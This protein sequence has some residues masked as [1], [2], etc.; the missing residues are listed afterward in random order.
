M[1]TSS[2]DPQQLLAPAA[3]QQS[4]LDAGAL[5]AMAIYDGSGENI[6]NGPATP[7]G[8]AADHGRLMLQALEQHNKHFDGAGGVRRLAPGCGFTLTQHAHYPE[9][10]NGFTV[11]WVTHAARNNFKAGLKDGTTSTIADG[12]YRNRFA[13]VRDTVA[14]VPAA[15]AAPGSPT[16]FGTQTALV[17]GL[18]D[19]VATTT[20]DHQVKVQFGWQRGATPNPGGLD[21]LSAKGGNAPGDSS[22]GAWV[23]V[24]EALA[25]PNWGSQFIPRIGTEVLIAFAEGDIDR[26]LIV[27]QLHNGVTPPPY[28]AGVD[29]GANHVGAL[30]GIDTANFE[31]G[32]N[33][34]QLDDTQD[35]VRM[36][37]ASSSAASELH[38]G[39]A[40]PANGRFVATGARRA[41]AALNCVPTRGRSCAARKASC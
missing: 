35:Q 38:L 1:L 27:G 11:L 8:D 10:A 40:G 39:P 17:V 21:H 9:G 15:I 19:S 2:W 33:Q 41:A 30:S 34:W 24:A 23:R 31:G 3:E 20:R 36:R 32:F 6:A 5:P 28:Q 7:G 29:G 13:C 14:L 37:L 12:T 18:P 16:A 4:H 22:C 25:G 26:P